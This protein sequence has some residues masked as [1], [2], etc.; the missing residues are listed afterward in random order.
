LDAQ[1]YF[2]P[3]L[4]PAGICKKRKMK[5]LKKRE[6]ARAADASQASPDLPACP[7]LVRPNRYVAV[8]FR[9]DGARA[10]FFARRR[11]HA[12]ASGRARVCGFYA[13]TEG[14][15]VVSDGWISGGGVQKGVAGVLACMQDVRC[16]Q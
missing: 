9:S 5:S 14:W 13:L 7:G 16:S 4:N 15:L 1:N 6:W 2:Y 11:M 10:F 3:F 12:M 8:R